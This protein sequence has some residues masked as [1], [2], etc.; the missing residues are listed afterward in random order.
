MPK[1]PLDMG[2]CPETAL[3]P[4]WIGAP[5]RFTFREEDLGDLSGEALP[6][7]F[8]IWWLQGGQPEEK[9]LAPQLHGLAR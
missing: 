5:F 8:E 6:N 4:T 2:Y 9:F 7:S 1:A 3:W